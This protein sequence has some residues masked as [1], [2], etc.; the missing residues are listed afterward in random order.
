MRLLMTKTKLSPIPPLLLI[1]LWPRPSKSIKEI[2][3]EVL[4]PLES[5]PPRYQIKTRI[6]PRAWATSSVIPVNKKVIIRAGIPQSHKT[7]G[8]L[9]NLHVDDWQKK[10]RIETGNL[11]LVSCYF[12]GSDWGLTRF[13]KWSQ[14]NEPSIRFPARPQDLKDEY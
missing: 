3:K 14:Y 6:K 1:N 9:G 11:Y 10:G 8:G 7:R 5:I 13:K 4:Q 2:S 12:Q